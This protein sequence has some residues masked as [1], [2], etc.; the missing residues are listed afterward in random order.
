MSHHEIKDEMIGTARKLPVKNLR[1]VVVLLRS[2]RKDKKGGASFA[3]TG[4]K[5]K[6]LQDKAEYLIRNHKDVGDKIFGRTM[7]YINEVHR[8]AALRKALK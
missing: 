3:V 2:G 8:A 7:A 5:K 1:R 6:E 4:L